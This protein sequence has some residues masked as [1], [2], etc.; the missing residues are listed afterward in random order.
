MKSQG[1]YAE[2][3]KQNW[4]LLVVKTANITNSFN[5]D[6]KFFRTTNMSKYGVRK[7]E[8]TLPATSLR[9]TEIEFETPTDHVSIFSSTPSLGHVVNMLSNQVHCALGVKNKELVHYSSLAD[10]CNC[11]K[12][13]CIP[14][15]IAP[16]HLQEFNMTVTGQ[17]MG[18]NIAI[19]TCIW[20]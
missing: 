19:Y 18:W 3:K 9:Y 15:Q 11:T 16:K 10:S 8:A 7:I 20:M 13:S 6:S 17:R 12:Y 5:I 2:H 1:I 14:E 4:N